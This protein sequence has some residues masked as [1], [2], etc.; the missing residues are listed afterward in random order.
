MP[1]LGVHDDLFPNLLP[2]EAD[3]STSDELREPLSGCTTDATDS[4]LV[5][6]T[7]LV[8]MIFSVCVCVCV[9]V[10]VCVCVYVCVCSIMTFMDR[11]S[12]V[13]FWP[14]NGYQ[15]E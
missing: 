7:H 6:L 8:L 12:C 5:V 9:Y 14:A 11:T 3:T 10:C 1:W 4:Q 15:S 13:L 2:F